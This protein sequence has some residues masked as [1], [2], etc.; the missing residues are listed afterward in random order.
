MRV[1]IVVGI[2]LLIYAVLR[3]LSSKV[4]AWG[5]NQDIKAEQQALQNAGHS[6]SYSSSQYKTAA[7][8]IYQ[9]AKGNGTNT[10]AIKSVFSQMNNL[11]DVLQLELEY[12]N[13]DPDFPS[14]GARLNYESEGWWGLSIGSD[15]T[16]RSV[17]EIL[18]EKNIPRKY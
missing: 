9:A 14:L 12:I 17:N 13:I 11:L 8:T 15:D 2:M 16:V 7:E 1:V 10:Q 18:S 6:L 5:N 4:K 3:S